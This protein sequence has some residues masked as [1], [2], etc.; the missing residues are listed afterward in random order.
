MKKKL[1]LIL[2]TSLLAAGIAQAVLITTTDEP[3]PMFVGFNDMSINAAQDVSFTVTA[4]AALRYFVIDEGN[5]TA[6]SGEFERINSNSGLSFSINGGALAPVESWIDYAG[7]FVVG[8]VTTFDSLLR[9]DPINVFV[10]DVVTLHAGTGSSLGNSLF[11]V[12]P[13]GDYDLFIATESGTMVGAI[14]EPS[15]LALVGV[16][17]A[18]IFGIRRF[19]L[20]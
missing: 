14:P 16:F 3:N 2:A 15:V 11:Q 19:F 10:G 12:M 7:T 20:I 6:N 5:V 1:Q 18:G 4:D 9:V 8:D 17:G 13:S